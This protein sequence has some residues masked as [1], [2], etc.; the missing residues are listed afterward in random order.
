MFLLLLSFDF[1]LPLVELIDV[2]LTD[3]LQMLVWEETQQRPSEIQTLEDISSII[4]ALL[5]ELTFE[6]LEELKV[7]SIIISQGFLTNDSLHSLGILTNSVESVKLVRHLRVI[8]SGEALTNGRLH[9][10]RE[11]WQHIDGWIDLSVVQISVDE[12]LTL[13]DISSQVRDWM[14]DIIIRHGQDR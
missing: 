12:D 13:S 10:T 6:L 2:L 9:E 1:I 14:G 3:L 8:N 7:K 5:K 4:G 11:G